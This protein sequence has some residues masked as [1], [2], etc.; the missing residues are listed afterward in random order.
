MTTRAFSVERTEFDESM[1][2]CLE[3][4]DKAKKNF[5]LKIYCSSRKIQIVNV[6]I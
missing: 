4:G 3:R 6:R 1:T 5:K 2:S